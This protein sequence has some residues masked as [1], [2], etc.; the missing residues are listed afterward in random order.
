MSNTTWNKLV[1]GDEIYKV[2]RERSVPYT[3]KTIYASSYEDEKIEGWEFLSNLKNPKK[4]K[5][6]LLFV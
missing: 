3:S 6:K 1:S 4:I 5:V 2:R